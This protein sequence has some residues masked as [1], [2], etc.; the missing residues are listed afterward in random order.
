MVKEKHIVVSAPPFCDHGFR[1]WL[2]GF[3]ELLLRHNAS[4]LTVANA[5]ISDIVLIQLMFAF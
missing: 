2:P 3:Q 4:M 5:Q 1:S